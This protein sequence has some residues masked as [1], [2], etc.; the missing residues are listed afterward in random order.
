MMLTAAAA[1]VEPPAAAEPAAE[2]E[3][4]PAVEPALPTAESVLLPPG[5]WSKGKEL[6]ITLFGSK[7]WQRDHRQR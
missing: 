3:P 4:P 5:I 7:K 1:E 6:H 2:V